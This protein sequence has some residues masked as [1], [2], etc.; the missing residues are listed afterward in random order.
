[1]TFFLCD[2]WRRL[3]SHSGQAHPHRALQDSHDTYSTASF[4]ACGY[5]EN[6]YLATHS[7]HPGGPCSVPSSR[8]SPLS[9]WTT[10]PEKLT[11]L[12][13]KNCVSSSLTLPSKLQTG[14]LG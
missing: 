9:V 7:L 5:V 8:S 4:T 1:M 10:P 13:T 14:T 3:R 12:H 6:A 11:L 2:T